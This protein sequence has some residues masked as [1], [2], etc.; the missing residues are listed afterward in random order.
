[1]E[2]TPFIV[3]ATDSSGSIGEKEGDWLHVKTEIAASHCLRVC[4]N[5]L[6]AVGA[7]PD[8]I[9]STVSNEFDDTGVMILEGIH[10][11]CQ[12][13]HITSYE[14]NGSSEENFPTMMTGFGI[15][16]VGHAN[17]LQWQKTCEGDY[18][19]IYGWPFV[20]EEVLEHEEDLLNAL[21]IQKLFK[22]YDIHDFLPCGSGGIISEIGV[23]CEQTELTLMHE[24]LDESF[25]SQILYESAGPSTCG[26]LTTPEKI[27]D[28]QIK[29]LGT[30]TETEEE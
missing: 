23:L 4:L 22:E 15:T 21:I 13:Y 5:E 6:Y 2:N 9:I 7:V 19:Y 17:K 29:L 1:M 11:T 16:V 30:F 10:E 24:R 20:G 3:I 25:D 14:I 26:I 18:C 12:R 27:T 8:I 28:E